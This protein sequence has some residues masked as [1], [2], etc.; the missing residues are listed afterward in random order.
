MCFK[1]VSILLIPFF[2]PVF[3]LYICR[4]PKIG[5]EL[6]GRL[7]FLN[8]SA[9]ESQRASLGVDVFIIAS[10]PFF[11]LYYLKVNLLCHKRL[12]FQLTI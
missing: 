8:I 5:N 9:S 2:Y 10:A 4:A 11:I 3:T 1:K 7:P 6:L 12:I